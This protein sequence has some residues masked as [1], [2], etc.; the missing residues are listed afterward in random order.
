M[1]DSVNWSHL[2]Y[3]AAC[4]TWPWTGIST[5]IFAMRTFSRFQVR[6][7]TLGADDF[8]IPI[9]WVCSRQF[10]S[11]RG[12]LL[13]L[14]QVFNIIR[15][16][17]FQIALGHAANI[18]ITDKPATVPPAAFWTVLSDSWSF[19][20]LGTPK[21]GVA[22]LVCRVFRPQKWLRYSIIGYCVGIY[23]LSI[24]GFIITFEQCH[25][26]AGQWDP[27]KYTN[28]KCWN[29][30]V[31]TIW[32][33][34]VSGEFIMFKFLRNGVNTNRVYL[35][36]SLCLHRYHILYLPRVR[37]LESPDA[38]QEE[39]SNYGSD[40]SWTCVCYPPITYTRQD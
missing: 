19:F 5:V 2:A 31:Q 38:D 4:S 14:S 33:C 9:S 21:L 18:S 10:Y 27:W 3:T 23:V 22:F 32:S 26:V 16:I 7:D 8:F 39:A 30:D 15:A 1:D 35:S 37:N 17:F 24:I 29:R 12:Q 34:C 13:N 11:M 40:G 6:G 20:S 25:P 28:V 36:S